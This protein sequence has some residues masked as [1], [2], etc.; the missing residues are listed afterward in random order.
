MAD[1]REYLPRPGDRCY[2]HSLQYKQTSVLACPC[3]PC[4]L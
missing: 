1:M 3:L 4:M 2:M